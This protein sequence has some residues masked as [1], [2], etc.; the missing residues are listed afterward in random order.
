MHSANLTVVAPGIAEALITT[1]AGLGAAIPAVLFYN[2]LVRKVDLIANEMD[3]LRSI[4]EDAVGG[5]IAAPREVPRTPER[6]ERE[7]I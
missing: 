5:D 1:V 4:L 7:T 2:L 6:H 3:R